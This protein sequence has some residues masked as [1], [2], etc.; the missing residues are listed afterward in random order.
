MSKGG[1]SSSNWKNSGKDKSE[2][3]EQRILGGYL[4]PPVWREVMQ[5]T[6]S[7]QDRQAYSQFWSHLPNLNLE[8]FFSSWK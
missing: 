8:A 5:K 6:E 4:M 2:I 1:Y 3:K 7:E